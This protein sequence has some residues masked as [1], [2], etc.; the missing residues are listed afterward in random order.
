M[1][2]EITW[3]VASK[4][5]VDAYAYLSLHP[6]T[7]NIVIVIASPGGD[8]DATWTMY[9]VLKS[10]GIR[11]I[12]IGAGKVFSA[13]TVLFLVGSDRY[14]FEETVFLFHEPIVVN[15]AEL[16]TVAHMEETI[17][18]ERIDSELFQIILEAKLKA[19][20]RFIKKLADP[21]KPT[22][23]K[24]NQALRINLATNLIKNLNQIKL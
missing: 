8:P 12:T 23:V 1:I 7:K 6:N 22:F 15:A 17:I 14:I 24:S 9:T 13:A 3:D 10:F 16:G 19:P 5:F 21:R 20:R 2:G 18:G 4:V 11:V